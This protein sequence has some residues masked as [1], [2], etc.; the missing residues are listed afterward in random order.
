MYLQFL[1]TLD[2]IDIRD[3]CLLLGIPERGYKRFSVGALLVSKT[4]TDQL[5]VSSAFKELVEDMV[6][7]LPRRLFRHPGLLEQIIDELGTLDLGV[8]GKEID[9]DELAESRGIIV[10]YRLRIPEC[11]QYRVTTEDLVLDRK[12]LQT[13][14]QIS[15]Q[16]RIPLICLSLAIIKT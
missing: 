6:V 10:L 2:I 15:Q 3:V 8:L 5:L 9:P 14:H 7:P 12:L 13:L 1:E 16:D 4:E 11:F